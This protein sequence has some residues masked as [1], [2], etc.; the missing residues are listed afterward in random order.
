MI[1]IL[2]DT[3]DTV[4][5]H[6]PPADNVWL[7]ARQVFDATGWEWKPQGLC[8]DDIC[9]P[10]PPAASP[11]MVDGDRLD[12]AAFWRHAGLPVVHDDA[13]STWVLG[14][15]A[16]RRA[17]ALSSLQAPDFALPDLDGTMHSLADLRGQRVFMA[18]WASW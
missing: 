15:G 10:V 7:D 8:Q 12:I 11:P 17:D 5:A 14:E 16:A 2:H 9:M 1:R 18:T 3:R 4:F 13:R 6:A